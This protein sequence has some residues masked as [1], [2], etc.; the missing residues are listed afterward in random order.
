MKEKI[1]EF[2]KQYLVGFI[3]GVMTVFSISVIAATYFPS[4]QTTYDNTNTELQ[5]TNVQDAIDELYGVCFPPKA[6]DQIIEDNG[7]EKDPYECRYFFTGKSQNNYIKFN[8]EN[9]RILSV[10]CD[11]RIKIV[12]NRVLTTRYE[13]NTSNSNDWNYASLNT[14]LNGDYY[15]GLT[16]I[17][18]NQIVS[19]NFSIGKITKN[20]NDLAGQVNGENSTTWNGKI[21]LPTVSEY[22]RTSSNKSRCGTL[23]LMNNNYGS[24]VSTTWMYNSNGYDWYTLT[25]DKSLHYVFLVN[26]SGNGIDYVSCNNQLWVRPTLYLSPEIKITNGDGSQS[27]PYT[28]E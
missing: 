7:L 10:E 16:E 23:S 20:N 2:A 14:T 6:G 22:I 25:A 4:N 9:W 19:S 3:L 12:R 13:W 5:S 15:N 18:K 17:A 26:I 21:A 28:I 11:G 24:C 27:N 8:N 1:K